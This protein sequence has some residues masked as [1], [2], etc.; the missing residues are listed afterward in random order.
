MTIIELY[1]LATATVASIVIGLWI[2]SVPLK[3]A[4]IIDMFWGALFVAIVWVLLPASNMTFEPRTYFMSLFVTLWGLRL[5]YH[6]ISRNLG[7]AEDGRYQ[8]WRKHGGSMWWLKT[9]YRIFLFQGLLA[10]LVATPIIAAF[11]R[12]QG[13]STLN[14]LGA[15]LWLFGFCY[16]L[17]ADI[18][19]S[20]YRETKATDDDGVLDTGLWGLSRHPN[21][22]GDALQWWGL[23]LLA[24]SLSTWWALIGPAVMT[25]IFLGISNDIL[26]KG[27]N[28]RR[29]D[30]AAYVANTP[31]FFPWSS[32][33]QDIS[34]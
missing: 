27:L 11:Y 17:V 8:L 6:L 29:P 2:I 20:R 22:F 31:K 9:L 28:K 25:A 15:G 16:E 14:L 33:K 24:L 21:Y 7:N 23:G 5:A 1:S 10:L 32:R 19:L 3:D 26:E 12:P 13:F 4:S 18:Q 30:Y 34:D